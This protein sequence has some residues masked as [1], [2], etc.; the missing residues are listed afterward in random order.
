VSPFGFFGNKTPETTTTGAPSPDVVQTTTTAAPP[1]TTTTTEAINPAVGAT[2]NPVGVFYSA[3]YVEAPKTQLEEASADADKA[4]GQ[5]ISLEDRAAKTEQEFAAHKKKTLAVLAE[6]TAREVGLRAELD[7][8]R[9]KIAAYEL[10]ASL[11][12]STETIRNLRS[13]LRMVQWGGPVRILPTHESSTTC[14]VCKEAK[15]LGH[16][17]DCA[18][19]KEIA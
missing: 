4:E 9:K 5:C 6:H 12:G 3:D 18:L 13:L 16:A 7:A 17:K 2:L 11:S 19:V 1:E 10:A 8:E 15:K 14:P